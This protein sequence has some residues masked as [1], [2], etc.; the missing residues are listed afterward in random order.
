MPEHVGVMEIQTLK[1]QNLIEISISDNGIGM[2]SAL[3]KEIFRPFKSFKSKNE[4]Q[5]LGLSLAKETLLR[6]H[7][8]IRAFSKKGEGSKFVME[9]KAKTNR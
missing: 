5:G 8:D 9:I 2:H 7:G 4:G 3:L 1:N 6:H